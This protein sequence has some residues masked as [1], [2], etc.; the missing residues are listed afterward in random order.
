MGAVNQLMM[1]VVEFFLILI[2][3]LGNPMITGE[4]NP[5]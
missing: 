5:K 4:K 2:R 1:Y 3:V